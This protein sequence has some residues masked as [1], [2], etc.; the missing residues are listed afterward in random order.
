MREAAIVSTARTPIGKAYRGAF[1]NT[2]SA[3]LGGYA[4]EHALKKAGLEPSRVQDVVMGA[5]LTTGVQSGDIARQVAIR[6]GIPVTTPAITVSKFCT[7]GLE[8]IVAGSY[9]VLQEGLDVVAAGG[10]ESISQIQVPGYEFMIEEPWIRQ[11]KPDY[12]MHMIETAEVVYDRYGVS[13]E[14]QDEFSFQSQQ[15]T[16]AAQAAGLLDDEI[17]PMESVKRVVNKE[18]GEESFTTVTLAHDEGNR[19]STTLEGLQALK[20][21][22]RADGCVTAGNASQLS[23]GA[24]AVIVMNRDTAE[25]EGI[26]PL[27]YFRGYTSVGVEPDE[28][29]IAPVY[30]VPALL[31][32]FGLSVNDIGLWELNE[33]FAVQAVYCRDKLGIPDELLNVNGGAISIGHPYGMSGARMA[34]HA[35]IEGKRRGAKYVVVTMCAATGLGGAGLFE[36]AL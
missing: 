8:A 13:R 27:G 11:N 14:S 6:A 4:V 33:A 34:G 15:R 12:Y 21:V 2:H 35:L 30:A 26:E 5:A 32:R 36:V 29:G 19:P 18:T 3:T 10:V 20:P 24:S 1:N 22:M 16:A 9:R 7:S 25:K 23:D 17:V 28:M 31:D